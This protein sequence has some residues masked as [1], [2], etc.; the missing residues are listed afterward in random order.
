MRP[1][2]CGCAFSHLLIWIVCLLFFWL[3]GF[4]SDQSHGP[5]FYLWCKRLHYWGAFPIFS[6]GGLWHNTLF[7]VPLSVQPLSQSE[8]PHCIFFRGIS[9]YAQ[10]TKRKAEL[11]LCW[12]SSRKHAV[13]LILYKCICS[14]TATWFLDGLLLSS[15]RVVLH[16]KDLCRRSPI[17][18]R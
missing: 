14:M 11:W 9:R 7:E 8:P 2:P 17:G 15:L 12:N 4:S 6:C 10:A 13:L 1:F 16:I 18:I 5:G 3:F